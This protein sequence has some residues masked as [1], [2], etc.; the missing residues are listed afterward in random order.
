MIS[1]Y[2]YIRSSSKCYKVNN[3]LKTWDEAM[4]T[5]YMEGGILAVLENNNEADILRETLRENLKSQSIYH[6]GIRRTI[7]QGDFYSVKGI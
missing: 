2:K 7:S 4:K 3:R 5:C 6:V 1:E